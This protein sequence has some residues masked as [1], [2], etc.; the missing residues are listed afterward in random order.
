MLT[1]G[2]MLNGIF[3]LWVVGSVASLYNQQRRSGALELVLC[4]PITVE[5][6]LGG[7]TRWLKEQFG[8]VLCVTALIEL[9]VVGVSVSNLFE[10]TER[11]WQLSL[12]W[13]VGQA[14]TLLPDCWALGWVGMWLSLAKRNTAHA[15][16]GTMLRLVVLPW[17]LAWFGTVANS[18]ELTMAHAFS[19]WFIASLVADLCFGLHAQANLRAHFRTY[20]ADPPWMRRTTR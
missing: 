1:W 6:L 14:V 7:T 9:I 19:S 15:F 4:T 11:V 10:N 13:L 3:K 8:W 20:A 5:H 17:S 16:F 18:Q 12:S 2:L